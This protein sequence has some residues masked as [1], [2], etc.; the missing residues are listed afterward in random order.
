MSTII[1]TPVQHVI[2]G[3]LVSG[4]EVE[5][6]SGAVHFA[7]P[8][9]DLDT[10]VW[11]RQ[12]P[13]PAFDVPLAEI[14]D[15]LEAT[16]KA[17]RKDEHGLLAEAY[18]LMARTSPL[19]LGVLKR[20]YDDLHHIFARQLVEFQ[21]RSELGDPA[22]LDGWKVMPAPDGRGVRVRAF[23]PRMVHILA[24]NVPGVA[25]G[26]IVRG[27]ITKGV[28]LLKLPS[29]D[30]YT[31]TALL[32]IM[33]QVAPGHPVV[34]SFSAVYWRGGD[35][36][37]ESRLFTP[38]YFD[39]LAA[40]GG[41][42][43]LRSAKNYIGPGFEL[44]SFDP[45]TSISMI[46]REAFAE[47]ADIEDVAERAAIDATPWN[48]S[49]CVASRFQ[50]VEASAQDADR[51][52]AALQRRMGVDRHIASAFGPRVPAELRDDIDVLRDMPPD[53]TVFGG[54]E[55]Q[56]IVIRSDT[57]VDFHPDGKIVNVVTVNSLDDAIRFATVATQTIGIYPP[58]RKASLRDR[59]MSA[60]AQRV[61]SLGQAANSR[62]GLPHDGFIALHRFM[63]WVND[64]D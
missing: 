22:F 43:S 53:Y 32:R 55:G 49:A 57:P 20:S 8:R 29:N 40:W 6:R 35:A 45:K 19:D 11:S 12:K 18:E 63:R 2:K 25:A 42:S 54:Y 16:G 62:P 17:V 44:I 39:K 46:G 26:S 59:L 61:V 9:L 64:E 27:A 41:E 33:A 15:L 47:G 10:L 13:G 28:H 56:G 21:I 24:G 7:T 34:R 38:I 4:T 31:A 36:A 30:L 3:E 14:V 60:G 48:Q 52:A 50:F 51:F 5:F 23:P 37:V 58:E 1:A